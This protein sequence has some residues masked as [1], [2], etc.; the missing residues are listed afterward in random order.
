MFATSHLFFFGDLNF[1]LSLPSTH[2]LA[3]TDRHADLAQAL[4]DEEGRASLKDFDQLVL[5]RDTKGTI[6]HG[7]HEGEFWRFKCSYKYRLG[8]VDH[9]E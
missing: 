8:E 7:F 6:F 3:G 5:E 4:S 9:Y 1:R 2:V